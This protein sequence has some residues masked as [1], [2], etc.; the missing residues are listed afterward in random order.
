MRDGIARGEQRAV[1]TSD[2]RDPV[3]AEMLAQV[4]Q[5][6]DL[7]HRRRDA[8]YRRGD[9]TSTA[10]LVIVDDHVPITEHRHVIVDGPEIE[11][12]PT[13]NGDDGIDAWAWM[14]RRL[15]EEACAVGDRDVAALLR[16]DDR[17]DEHGS[18]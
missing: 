17:G 14:T 13:I 3:Q 2:E 9:P 8:W 4:V 12:G 5:V 11:T 15:I 7:P 18:E 6:L 10:A 1:R 16:R